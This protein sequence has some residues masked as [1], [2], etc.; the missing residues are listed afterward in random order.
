MG[1]VNSTKVAKQYYSLLT[2][3]R[4]VATIFLASNVRASGISFLTQGVS[5]CHDIIKM[6]TLTISTKA[7]KVRYKADKFGGQF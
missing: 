5:T 2:P 3:G 6:T 1:K 4:P 7:K